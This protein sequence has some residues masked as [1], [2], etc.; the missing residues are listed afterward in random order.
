MGI[1]IFAAGGAALCLTIAGCSSDSTS[2]DSASGDR[3]TVVTAMYPMEFIA[4]RV[5]GD[6]VE[7]ISLAEPG[8]DSHDLELTPQ[9]ITSI[10]DA[11]L[12]VYI[13]GFAPA[14]DD[15]VN[16]YAG[17]RAIDVTTLVPTLTGGDT[18]DHDHGDEEGHSDEVADDDLQLSA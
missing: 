3:P 6:Q 14:V 7:S 18:H 12:V 2:S 16:E 9:Q 17:D 8:V 1:K 4:D 13:S 10:T 5:G 15:A 11:D